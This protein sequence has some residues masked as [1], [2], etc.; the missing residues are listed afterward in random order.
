MTTST[1]LLGEHAHRRISLSNY[2][3]S[4][5]FHGPQVIMINIH[6]SMD[7]D[8]TFGGRY[9]STF[10]GIMLFCYQYTC[11]TEMADK[12]KCREKCSC[13]AIIFY[14]FHF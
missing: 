12:L 9:I 2:K 11:Y 6:A 10:E 1:L 4:A 5:Q 14:L 7:L 8:Q 3:W 13:S